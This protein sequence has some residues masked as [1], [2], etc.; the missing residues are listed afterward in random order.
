MMIESLEW[1]NVQKKDRIGD[2]QE[3]LR[4][5]PQ[6]K[7]ANDA[8]Q[9]IEKLERQL[10]N[11]CICSIN[12]EEKT[13]KVDTKWNQSTTQD[14]SPIGV[15]PLRQE[16]RSQHTEA[17]YFIYN[18]NT[19]LKYGDKNPTIGAL[20]TGDS[21][22][23]GNRTY[24]E[25]KEVIERIEINKLSKLVGRRAT[26]D[27]IEEEGK[28]IAKVID[29]KHGLFM[30]LSGGESLEYMGSGKCSCGK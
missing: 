16:G 28:R 24:K 15:V 11:C 19:I 21:L 18:N 10:K 26:I 25:G 2:Y 12:I 5:Y 7:F 3:F 23:W 14:A 29:L 30:A 20:E 9:R 4:K 8:K 1:S 6:S 22:V 27:W 17:S 13:I